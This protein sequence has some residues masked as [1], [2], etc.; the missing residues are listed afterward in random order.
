[1]NCDFLVLTWK[2]KGIVFIVKSFYVVFPCTP[3]YS[4]PFKWQQTS[5]IFQN[6]FSSLMIKYLLTKLGQ[7]RWENILL[8]FMKYGSCYIWS[9]CHNHEPNIFPSS[10]PTQ[11][12]STCPE[13]LNVYVRAGK[14]S[15][16][17]SK[18]LCG[19]MENFAGIH[20]ESL[21]PSINQN[22]MY[23]RGQVSNCILSVQT[24]SN[25]P[26][27]IHQPNNFSVHT[28][29]SYWKFACLLAWY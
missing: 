6:L 25:Y 4:I 15:G 18:I 29:K 20:F 23:N 17:P 8:S 13:H 11:S 5:W 28:L 1:M 26:P 3:V 22:T 19:I 10:P 14:M 9:F 7:A 16:K 12:I 27:M 2:N 24:H 21:L